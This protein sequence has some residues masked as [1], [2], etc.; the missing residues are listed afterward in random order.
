M[1]PRYGEPVLRAHSYRLRPGAYGILAR[2][3]DLLLTETD[4]VQLPGGGI[5]AGESPSRAL[6]REVM[7]ETGWRIGRPRRLGAFRRFVYLPEDG[8]WAEKLCTVFLA[9]PVRQVGP[10]SE[11]GHRAI[12]VPIEDADARLSV[13]GDRMLFRRWLASRARR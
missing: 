2:D 7:E 6:R 13:L 8:F 10:P 12:W 3:G 4:E 5:D 11:P 9:R 1:I